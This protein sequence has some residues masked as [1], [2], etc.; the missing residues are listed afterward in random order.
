MDVN[1][2]IR[3]RSKSDEKAGKSTKPINI[4]P[5]ITVWLQ[6]FIFAAPSMVNS[7]ADD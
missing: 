7:L 4:L 3:T 2:T 1:E 5:L 6:V